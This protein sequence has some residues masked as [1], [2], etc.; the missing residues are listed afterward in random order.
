VKLGFFTLAAIV[1]PALVAGCKWSNEAV[2]VDQEGR[3]YYGTV[4][5]DSEYKTGAITFPGTPYGD[6]TGP[7]TLVTTGETPII[8]LANLPLLQFSGKA[9]LG[10]RTVRFLECD[11]TAEFRSKGMGDMKMVG[12]GTC[13]DHQNGTYDIS[14]Q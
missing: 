2:L 3:I 4:S 8:E 11:I 7:F 14:F 9:H 6:I 5:F 12:C 10:N 1:L 13:R